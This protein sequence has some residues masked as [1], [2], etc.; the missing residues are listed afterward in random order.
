LLDLSAS[1]TGDAFVLSHQ[2]S[3]PLNCNKGDTV[4]AKVSASN[5]YLPGPSSAAAKI[6]AMGLPGAV[7]NVTAVKADLALH[8]S[9]QLPSDTGF[10]SSSEAAALESVAQASTCSS[11]DR[12]AECDFHEANNA[13]GGAVALTGLTKGTL[14]YVRAFVRNLVGDSLIKTTQVFGWLTVPVLTDTSTVLVAR[15]YP[16]ST[17]F[18]V[19]QNG[20]KR[21]TIALKLTLLPAALTPTDVITCDFNFTAAATP[22]SA[23]TTET[24]SVWTTASAADSSDARTIDVPLPAALPSFCASGCSAT[25]FVYPASDAAQHASLPV[26]FFNYARPA[27]T[28]VYPRKGSEQG[29]SVVSLTVEDYQDDAATKIPW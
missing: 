12:K 17:A 5:L 20:A 15:P 3:T 22:T 27:V 6:I 13:T 23:A 9:F 24:R 21:S 29:G 26:E 16:P 11:F 25:L 18:H 14:Y 7:T 10:G 19:W 28:S 4:S 1:W 8:V 2:S